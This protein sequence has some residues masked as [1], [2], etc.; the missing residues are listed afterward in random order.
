M[1]MLCDIRL[2]EGEV[3]LLLDA[4][5]LIGDKKAVREIKT[6]LQRAKIKAGWE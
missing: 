1:K 4:L 2:T 3:D 6:E 5:E